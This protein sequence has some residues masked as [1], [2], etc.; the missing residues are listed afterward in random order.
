MWF[1]NLCCGLIL[2]MLFRLIDQNIFNLLTWR[3]T[4]TFIFCLLYKSHI[5]STT[6]QF[7]VF[8]V[9][10]AF[11]RSLFGIFGIFL[12]SRSLNFFDMYSLYLLIPLLSNVDFDGTIL[13]STF[14]IVRVLIIYPLNVLSFPLLGVLCFII[15]NHLTCNCNL[16]LIDDMQLISFFSII[17]TLPMNTQWIIS[18]PF[19]LFGVLSIF[20]F[21]SMTYTIKY[22]RKKLILINV[23]EMIVSFSINTFYN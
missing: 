12:C 18:F 10:N 4:C 23:A 3:Y 21:Y 15:S 13:I 11:I 19:I 16:N 7:N 17:L 14:L 8:N 20:F 1:I 2:D 22:S 9:L 6:N 5:D